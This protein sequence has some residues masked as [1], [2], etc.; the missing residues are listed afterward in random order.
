M[1]ISAYIASLSLLKLAKNLPGG[2]AQGLIWGL[3]ALGVL[4]TFRLLDVA[5]L[6]VDGSFTLG[7][8]VTVMLII[9]GW[10]AWLAMLVA[11]IAG[12]LAGLCT[13]LLH[14]K[15]GIPVILAGILTQFSLYSINLRIM[16]MAANKALSVDKYNLILSSRNITS[17]IL[18]SLVIAFVLVCVFYWYFGT[19]QGSALRATGSNPAMSRALGIDIG[20][21]KILG[22]AISNGVV[23]LSGGLMSQYQG[24]ADIN[25]GRGAIVIGL[26]AVIIGEVLGKA[27]LGKHLN[28][29]GTM[30]FVVIGG[31][32]YYLVV[33]LVLWLRLNSNDL[34]LITAV[35]VALFLA[36]PYLRE[37]RK[38]S[39]KRLRAKEDSHA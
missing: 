30:S 12:I 21:M 33:V 8:A 2:I 11:V 39:F 23:A 13:G 29:F 28:F 38:T 3:M 20:A 5:D 18:T 1:T 35:I 31:V 7:A 24:F 14:V 9:A 10:P 22:L 19:E 25:M 15:L 27:I 26:A 36:V 4:I 16:G 34:K 17:A 6:T 37:Q 32:V